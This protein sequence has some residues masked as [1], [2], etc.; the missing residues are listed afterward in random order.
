MNNDDEPP[1]LPDGLVPDREPGSFDTIETWEQWLAEVHTWPA[2]NAKEYPANAGT[3][4]E[5]RRVP[6]RP[7]ALSNVL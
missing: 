3:G 4:L 1:A 5:I 2:G 6:S 7:F